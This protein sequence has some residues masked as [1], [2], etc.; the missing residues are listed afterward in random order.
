M[1][2]TFDGTEGKPL[3]LAT[4]KTWTADY[5]ASLKD[6]D[7]TLAHFFGFQIINKILAEK[8]CMGIRVYYGIDDA[9][10][11]QVMLVGAK[12]NG[13]NLFPATD[14]LNPNDPNTIADFSYPCPPY[15]NTI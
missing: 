3:A 11:K 9:G 8:G 7:T 12:E 6:P 14:A 5:K 10:E 1:A 13:D 4:F 2:Y 15:C